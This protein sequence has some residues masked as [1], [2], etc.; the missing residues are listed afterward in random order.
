MK[1]ALYI[2][3]STDE[4]AASAD[5][6][7]RGARAWCTRNGHTVVALYRDV[8]Y[9]GAEWMKRTGVL[10]LQA[11]A[12]R[13]ERPFD[14]VVVR[15]VDRLG[16]DA[17]RLPKLL[18]D[19]HEHEVQVIEWSTGRV[20]EIDG[21][22]AL[23]VNVLAAA[24]AYDRQ[25]IAHRT[26]TSHATRAARGLVTGGKVYGY[27]NDR[28]AD[29]VHYVVNATEAA[30]VRDIFVRRAVTGL[31]YRR[32]ACALNAEGVPSPRASGGGSGSWCMEEV[33]EILRSTRYKGAATWGERRWK[34]KGGTR[35]SNRVPDTELIT[36]AVPAIVEP[37]LW[38]R[39]QL[40]RTHKRIEAGRGA[41]GPRARYLLTGYAVCGLCGHR[42]ASARTSTG[43]GAGRRILPAYT[44]SGH[45]NRGLCDAA[46]YAPTDRLDAPVLDW[47]VNDVLDA[48]R[49]AAG[50]ARARELAARGPAVNPILDDL[51]LRAHDLDA[52]IA[53]VRKVVQ[54]TDDETVIAELLADLTALTAERA[55]VR[56][57]LARL[58]TP[59]VGVPADL[60]ARLLAT[61]AQ[62]RAVLDDARHERPDLVR[63]VLGMVLVG[64]L[65][66]T[67]EG[68][69]R[70]LRFR[71]EGKGSAGSLL[72]FTE[73]PPTEGDPNRVYSVDGFALD[74]EG[75]RILRAA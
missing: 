38:E 24:A 27:D 56:D 4:Q 43:S 46:Y 29:G 51:E 6:Q 30:V 20:V 60:E 64:R 32:I 70:S 44:C 23:I 41:P 50:I 35:T 40:G 18:H 58:R 52:R 19:L 31:S 67:P 66:I 10:D 42:L 47:L 12:T 11:D 9:S 45:R 57:E 7:E 75:A 48:D 25:M 2:R 68:K 55:G 1:V 65:T 62:L 71:L 14:A 28:R 34:Y 15:D 3:V 33:R 72:S 59:A 8:G 36:Y 37:D 73:N 53:R 39:A 22:G 74:P 49:I 63:E 69:G 13:K 16:R 54:R 61:V 26:R 17:V 5:E 21:A